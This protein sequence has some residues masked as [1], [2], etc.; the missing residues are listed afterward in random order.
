[1]RLILFFLLSVGCVTGFVEA[2]PIP[3]HLGQ[4]TFTDDLSYFRTVANYVNSGTSTTT[5]P[6]G[7]SYY[8]LIDQVHVE[9]DAYPGLRLS[10]NTGLG[11]AVA[12]NS[13]ATY[14]GTAVTEISLGAQ[15]WFKQKSFAIVPSLQGGFPINR[16]STNTNDSLVNE[17]TV[18]GEPGAWAI[19]YMHPFAIYGYLGYRYQDGG[20]AGLMT[21]DVGGSY[22]FATARLRVGFRGEQTLQKDNLTGANEPQRNIVTSK[23]DSGSFRYYSINPEYYEGYGEF[24]WIFSRDLEAGGG[25]AQSFYGADSAAGFTVMAMVRYRIPG[26]ARTA[27]SSGSYN[28][29]YNEFESHDSFQP[30]QE[31]YDTKIFKESDPEAD[32]INSNRRSLRPAQQPAVKKPK[33]RKKI[34]TMIQETEKSLEK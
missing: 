1:M 14:T 29:R 16:V 10:A 8:S 33:R 7:G 27:S 32:I 12:N 31:K 28:S 9:Y 25:V 2:E 18:W 11:Y 21:S 23:V 24:D 20:R 30:E 3:I 34:D 5:L 15:Y 4:W 22:R 26:D 17:G 13:V 6:N 19:G